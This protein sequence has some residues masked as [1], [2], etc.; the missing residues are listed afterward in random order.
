MP[1]PLA[2]KLA[3]LKPGRLYIGGEWSDAV[4]GATTPDVNPAT[5]A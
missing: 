1:T 4:S 5:G 3:Q 2:P